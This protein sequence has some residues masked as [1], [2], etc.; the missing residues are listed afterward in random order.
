MW[1]RRFAGRGDGWTVYMD[2]RRYAIAVKA[3]AVAEYHLFEKGAAVNRPDRSKHRLLWKGR[4]T[5]AV[6]D[7]LETTLALSNAADRIIRADGEAQ[8]AQCYRLMPLAEME[9]HACGKGSQ[10]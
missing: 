1:L 5:R 7:Y 6:R 4:L 10:I 9:Q 3:G 8:C 2:G